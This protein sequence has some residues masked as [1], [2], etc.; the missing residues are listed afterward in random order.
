MSFGFDMDDFNATIGQTIR[1][2]CPDKILFAAAANHGAKKQHC[3][4]SVREPGVICFKSCNSFGKASD[5]SPGNSDHINITF[6]ALSEETISA[7]PTQ[8]LGKPRS[9]R[10]MQ[11]GRPL[12][13]PLQRA[14]QL[15]SY[16]SSTS[17]DDHGASDG[18]AIFKEKPTEVQCGS[19]E[20]N[21][22]DTGRNERRQAAL[23]LRQGQTLDAMQCAS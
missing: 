19:K 10:G 14:L 17:P 15:L 7:Y 5:H 13:C 6:F 3:A 18:N 12:L 16:N 8:W 21:D 11:M 9:R 20:P 2:N 23:D 4:Y 22:Q 1:N